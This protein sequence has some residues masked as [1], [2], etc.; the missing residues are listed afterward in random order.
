MS[1]LVRIGNSA[2]DLD[3]VVAVDGDRVI[4]TDG[5][6]IWVSDK[7]KKALLDAITARGGKI[8]KPEGK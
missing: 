7:T 3:K 5:R 2:F 4:F 6:G 1:N 8:S